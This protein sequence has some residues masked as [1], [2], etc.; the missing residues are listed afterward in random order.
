MLNAFRAD[1]ISVLEAHLKPMRDD[2]STMKYQI[3]DIKVSTEKLLAE[4]NNMKK[5]ISQL[6]QASSVTVSKISSLETEVEKLKITP[7]SSQTSQILTNE[8]II[9]E[10]QERERRSKNIIVV[11]IPEPTHIENTLR[12]N[13]DTSSVQ[14]ILQS[15]LPVNPT[16]LK[17]VRLGN[18]F[19]GKARPIK[20]ILESSQQ[21]KDIMKSR[22]KLPANVRIYSDKTPT[23]K[24][25]L[26]GLS[27]EL[28]RRTEAGEKNLIIKYIKGTPKI[29]QA[30][31]N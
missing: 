11:G 18:F 30:A 21:A 13:E 31:K 19:T 24:N 12:N 1:M 23:E 25:I 16:A 29:I 22:N 8:S 7:S 3:D 6:Q 17:T 14:N 20:V 5:E 26:N 15:L 9:H 4:H 10:M 2:I 28:S 27:Q